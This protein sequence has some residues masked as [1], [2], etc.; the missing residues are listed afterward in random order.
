[1]FN[2]LKEELKYDIQNKTKLNESQEN[3]DK[4]LEKTQ[5]QLSELKEYFDKLQNEIKIIKNLT[6]MR[7][8]KTQINKIRNEKAI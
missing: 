5:K 2:K 6:N 8:E 4:K 3:T 1:M 7:T